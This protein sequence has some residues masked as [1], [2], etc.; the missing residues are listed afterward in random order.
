M[1]WMHPGD[2]LWSWWMGGWGALWCLGASAVTVAVA[3]W[4]VSRSGNGSPP[5]VDP[6]PIDALRI[7]E[8]LLGRGEIDQEE[9]DARRATLRAYR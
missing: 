8:Q 4:V 7:L 3:L 1:F 2:G 9:F 6:A 5:S